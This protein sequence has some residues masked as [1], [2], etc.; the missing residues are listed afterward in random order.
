MLID[1]EISN[2]QSR[3]DPCNRAEED[4]DDEVENVLECGEHF[5]FSG[6]G[7]VSPRQATEEEKSEHD[8]PEQIGFLK[9]H[10]IMIIGCNGEE[11][12]K[13]YKRSQE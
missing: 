9:V 1:G 4:G 2:G 11:V 5:L 3:A 10:V 12:S 6:V 13:V 7:S 8:P